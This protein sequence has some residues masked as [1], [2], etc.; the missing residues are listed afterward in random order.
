MAKKKI[1]VGDKPM[2]KTDIIKTLCEMTELP[3]KDVVSVLST[4]NEVIVKHVSKRG[5]GSF[6][7]PGF[8]KIEVV[9]KPAVKA[10]KGINPFTGEETVFKAKPASRKV[11][12]KALKQLK[13]SAN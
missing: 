5:P 13:D 11:K 10:R 12:V 6:T 9:K 8:F 2:T 3:K 7:Y 1:T 4:F